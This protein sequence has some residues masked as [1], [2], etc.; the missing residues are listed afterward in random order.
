MKPLKSTFYLFLVV[1]FFN[2]CRKEYSLENGGAQTSSGTWE[3]KDSLKQFQGNMDTAYIEAPSGINKVLH[4]IGTSLDGSQTFSMNLYADTFK[5]GTYKASLFQSSF[6]YTIPAKTLYQ[7]DQLIGEFIV[8][9]TSFGNNAISGTFS[10]TA[11]DSAGN[12]KNLSEGKFTST[13]GTGSTTGSS[14]VL[15]DSSGFCAPVTLAGTFVQGVALTSANTVQVEVT[16]AVAGAYSITSNTVNGVTFS[17]AGTFTSPGVQTVQLT[18]SGTPTNSGDQNFTMSYGNSQC[19][20]KINF[21]NPASGIL[22]A[23]GGNC[24]PITIAGV[25]RQAVAL[26]SSNTVQIE[27][28]VTTPG[29]YTITT[30]A[31]NGV[32]FSKSGTFT[33]AGV[34]SIFLTGIGTPVNPGIQAFAITFGASTC[35]FNVTFEAGVMPS[36]DYFPLTGNSNWTYGLVGGTSADD[37]KTTVIGYSPSIG[38]NTYNT[39]EANT[40]PP[41]APLDSEYYRKPG[42]DYYQYVN[43][44]NVVPFDGSVEGEFIFLK[45]NVA[46][47]T[48]WVSP[49]ISGTI[50]PLPVSAFI[51]MTILEKG[52]AVTIGSFNFQDVIKVQYEYFITGDPNPVETDERWFAKNVG[53]IHDS[54]SDGTTTNSFDIIDYQVF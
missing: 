46:A 24:T 36:G 12:I 42:G 6:D 13:I 1:I 8:N 40:V 49:T 16:V 25:Y 28:N 52:V 34:Q 21:G 38:G 29:D 44:T 41:S 32:S 54:F 14:G 43:Y 53:E 18:G 30:D 19:G 10:G 35:N 20:F 2:A 39:I 5:T 51:K 48:T 15:G 4:L 27:V 17:K 33:V 45:D 31:V 50:G 9:V 26:G 47:G 7:A 3:F 37:I 22:G 23:G 11:M